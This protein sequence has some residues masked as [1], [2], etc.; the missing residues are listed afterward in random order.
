[1]SIEKNNSFVN[2]EDTIGTD[3]WNPRPEIFNHFLKRDFVLCSKNV[4]QMLL[5]TKEPQSLRELKECLLHSHDV[6]ERVLSSKIASGMVR[7]DK[8]RYSLVR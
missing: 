3:T 4:Q 1:M 7:E 8:G 6:I 2:D 5:S